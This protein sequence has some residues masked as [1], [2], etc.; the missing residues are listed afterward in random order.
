MPEST[1]C[2]DIFDNE[3]PVDDIVISALSL[4]DSAVVFSLSCVIGRSLNTSSSIFVIKLISILSELSE[5][6]LQC[7]I[8]GILLRE[9]KSIELVQ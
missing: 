5:L 4:S 2:S 3:L 8:I 6:I 1:V 9:Y 7:S